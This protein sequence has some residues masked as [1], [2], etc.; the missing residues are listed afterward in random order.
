MIKNIY[1]S[2]FFILL[3]SYIFT[4]TASYNGVFGIFKY[5]LSFCMLTYFYFYGINKA[6]FRI[7]SV[8]LIPFAFLPMILM[9]IGYTDILIKNQLI[10]VLYY[11]L[12]IFLILVAVDLFSNTIEFCKQ[13]QYSVFFSL[14]FLTIQNRDI[15]INLFS[16]LNNILA[17]NRGIRTYLGFI[18]PNILALVALVGGLSTIYLIYNKE[19]NKVF[20]WISLIFIT[21]IIINAGSRTSFFCILI[22]LFFIM[23]FKFLKIMPLKIRI[24]SVTICSV[25]FMVFFGNMLSQLN[26]GNWESLDLDT[27]TSG[28]LNNQ[29][30]TYNFLK[31][32]GYLYFGIGNLNSSSFYSAGNVYASL[33]NTDS[34][35]MYYITTIGI[36]GLFF[37]IIFLISLFWRLPNNSYFGKSIFLV[38]IITSLFEHTLIVPSSLFSFYFLIFILIEINNK[39]LVGDVNENSL[40]I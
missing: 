21:F 26:I 8:L 4:Y 37:I 6:V 31:K 28:R 32:F 40:D 35:L 34:S 23:Y 29:I 11:I 17:N 33:L 27:L 12:F 2:L 38:W 36:V 15:S 10:N 39:M 3:I 25:I 22:F 5:G 7:L 16:L 30:N 1:K 13:I 19:K 18:N 24:I 14:L 20:N 9:I